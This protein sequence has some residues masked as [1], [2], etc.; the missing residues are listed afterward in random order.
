VIALQLTN[1]L[2]WRLEDIALFIF[3]TAVACM[4]RRFILIF[5]PILTPILA[6]VLA[7][8]IPR[9]E[10]AKDQFLLN[11][12]LMA[13]MLTIIVW[14]F[15]SQAALLKTTESAYPVAAVDYLNSHTVPGPMYNTY[16]FGG[17]LVMARGPE[18]K[19][20]LDGRS[21][22]YEPAG[23][24]SDYFA[25]AD[26]K[27]NALATLQKYGFQSCLLQHNEALATVLAALPGWQRVYEDGTSILFVRRSD[28]QALGTQTSVAAN[29][30]LRQE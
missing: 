4:H 3:A 15:P 6:V 5:V 22:L 24:L 14:L 11:A 28:S 20:F 1:R 10:R 27:P 9:Y 23:V 21:E 30:A 16:D 13:V 2:K 18:N 12:G 29:P 25:I 26:V 19:V 17:Y 7:G 8:W